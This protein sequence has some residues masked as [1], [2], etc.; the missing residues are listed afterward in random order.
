M[1]DECVFCAILE[2]TAPSERLIETDLAFAFMNANPAALG[3]ALVIPKRHATDIWD[4]SPETGRR[5]DPDAAGGARGSRCILAGRP[6]SLPG[7]PSGWLA[8]RVPFP[9]PRRPEMDGRSLDPE[10]GRTAGRPAGHPG[11]SRESP[12]RASVTVT[13]E[14]AGQARPSA[15]L[16][17]RK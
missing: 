7:E 16:A 10:L 1:T 15:S 14:R 2:G 12:Y 8:E 4:L 13:R 6:K 3:H 11:R 17:E 9:Y 5:L